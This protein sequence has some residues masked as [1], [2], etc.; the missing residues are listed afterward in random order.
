[1][2]PAEW[3][4]IDLARIEKIR[5]TKE[6]AVVHLVRNLIQLAWPNRME[7]LRRFACAA[8]FED[9]ISTKLMR[10]LFAAGFSSSDAARV[11]AH[12]GAFRG[13]LPKVEGWP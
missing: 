9:E 12:V 13:Q 4:V 7:A 11:I 2:G 3:A 8:W 1:L 10:A 5:W 6:N